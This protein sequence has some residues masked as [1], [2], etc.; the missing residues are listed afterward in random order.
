MNKPTVNRRKKM[1]SLPKPL[2]VEVATGW[3]IF[4]AGPDG[5]NTLSVAVFPQRFLAEE[6][7][8]QLLNRKPKIDT[9]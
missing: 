8:E 3:T 6:A 5:K 9:A 7:L 4:L 1:H 2:I